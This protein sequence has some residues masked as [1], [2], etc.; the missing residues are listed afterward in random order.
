MTVGALLSNYEGKVDFYDTTTEKQVCS[1]TGD[2]P[3]IDILTDY[4]VVNWTA[5]KSSSQP[6]IAVS[7][8]FTE[9]PVPEPDV[10][11]ETGDEENT[12]E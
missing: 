10:E 2:S 12:E 8:Q 3:V 11:P 5:V 4:D 9:A 1:T 7:C 6:K